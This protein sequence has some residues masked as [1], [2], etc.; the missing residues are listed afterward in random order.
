[1]NF[2]SKNLFWK[3]HKQHLDMLYVENKINSLEEE[4][5]I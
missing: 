2:K 4:Y 3:K 5:S 1:M